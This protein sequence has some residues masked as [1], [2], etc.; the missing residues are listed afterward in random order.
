[1]FEKSFLPF[2]FFYRAFLSFPYP[3]R[4]P[5]ITFS[6]ILLSSNYFYRIKITELAIL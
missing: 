2:V 3:F 4:V 1:M 5:P 6:S